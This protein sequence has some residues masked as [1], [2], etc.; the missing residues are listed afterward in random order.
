MLD[1]SFS[2]LFCSN[3]IFHLSFLNSNFIPFMCLQ[4]FSLEEEVNMLTC[5]LFETYHNIWLQQFGNMGTCFFVATSNDQVQTF[6]QSS[7]YY[8]FLQGGTFGISPNKNE[9][10]LC[11]ASQFRDS[12]QI[13]T[14][15]TKYTLSSSFSAI[16]LRLEG[17]KV[18]E[19]T[20]CKA[21]LPPGSKVD[22]HQHDQVNNSRPKVANAIAPINQLS[23][24]D[25]GE[26]NDHDRVITHNVAKVLES[27][28]GDDI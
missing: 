18:F 23:T 2:R 14:I 24:M 6:M 28:Y 27:L 15:V 7:F 12:I 9:L 5:K 20:K 3:F 21:Y 4:K 13:I 11:R 8:A 19:S 22:S 10:C 16:I 26:V 17:E 25:V 1:V